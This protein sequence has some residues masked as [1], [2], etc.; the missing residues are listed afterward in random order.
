M[1]LPL[2]VGVDGSR[3]SMD[4]LE[5][6]AETARL[7]GVPLR[8]VHVV[9]GHPDLP[10]VTDPDEANDAA[11]ADDRNVLTDAMAR[12]REHG[13]SVGLT[14]A[15]VID[16]AA[17]ALIREGRHATALVVGARGRG[18]FAGLLL[19][20]VS[21]AVA[22]RASCPVAV[23]RGAAAHREG[24][25]H[26]V[27]VGVDAGASS[28]TAAET[29]FHEASLR[30]ADLVA[31][32]AWRPP[33]RDAPQHPLL[34]GDVIGTYRRQAREVLDAA[35]AGLDAKYP[36]VAVRRR[37]AQ[38]SARRALLK[39]AEGADLLVVGALRPHGHLGLHLGMVNHGVLHHAPCPVLLVPQT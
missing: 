29:A 9:R 34:G 17:Q 10:P 35:V 22:A 15:I 25:Y 23:V 19:G 32:H 24:R 16:D 13:P 31:V 27:V 26:R 33:P 28:R 14:G 39:E 1:E 8:L 3:S 7:R 2:V 18:E 21:L 11:G 30:G 20:S 36:E 6:A 4:A 5:W 38:G 37:L 12:A